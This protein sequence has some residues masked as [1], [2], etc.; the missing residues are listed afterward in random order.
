MPLVCVCNDVN[1]LLRIG[2]KLTVPETVGHNVAT[3]SAVEAHHYIHNEIVESYGNG[4][5]IPGDVG[6]ALDRLA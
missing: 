2:L 4:L 3:A 1:V 6:G 5:T